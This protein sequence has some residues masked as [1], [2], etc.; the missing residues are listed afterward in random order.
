MRRRTD[1][2]LIGEIRV[3]AH[4]G[5]LNDRVVVAGLVESVGDE[6]V[7]DEG[8][9]AVGDLA[10]LRIEQ[11]QGGVE[12]V[13]VAGRAQVE[14]PGLAF[15]RDAEAEEVEIAVKIETAVDRCG[16]RYRLGNVKTAVGLALEKVRLIADA[17]QQDIRRS[18]RRHDAEIVR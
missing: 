4:V 5:G 7:P 15:V 13:A 6:R 14:N 11:D 12:S 10:A 16:D 3:E 9:F 2:E 17:E 8:V 18:S 1:I